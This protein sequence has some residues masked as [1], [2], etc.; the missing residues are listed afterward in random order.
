MRPTLPYAEMAML[1]EWRILFFFLIKS[2]INLGNPNYMDT[3]VS[4]LYVALAF[5]YDPSH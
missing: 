1:W 4:V 2:Y 3:S 5:Y